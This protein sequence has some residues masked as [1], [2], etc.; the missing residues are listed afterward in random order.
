MEALM[1]TREKLCT[2]VN[3][4]TTKLTLY[5]SFFWL[6]F[7]SAVG[8]LEFVPIVVGENIEVARAMLLCRG[9][10][11]AS[12]ITGSSVHNQRIERLWRDVFNCVCHT[13]TTI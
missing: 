5:S 2:S 1:A 11:R 6:Q 12:H 3:Q 8:H 7:K 10:D 4:T 13:Y 9:L